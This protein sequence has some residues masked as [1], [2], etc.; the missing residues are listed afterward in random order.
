MFF[1]CKNCDSKFDTLKKLTVHEKRSH[2]DRV[3]TCEHCNKVIIEKVLKWMRHTIISD[4]INS[5]GDW[6]DS[7]KAIYKDNAGN[8][9]PT[10]QSTVND[11]NSH[12][13][14]FSKKILAKYP[15]LAEI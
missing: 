10:V 5:L 15:H 3:F 2:D 4:H 7:E 9:I 12:R 11:M 14:S 1:S 8:D 13:T 6:F